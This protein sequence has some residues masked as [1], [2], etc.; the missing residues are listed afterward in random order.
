MSGEG[1][2]LSAFDTVR[3]KILAVAAKAYAR[4]KH[5]TMCTLTITDFG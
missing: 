5:R 2:Y 4:G 1:E 3:K